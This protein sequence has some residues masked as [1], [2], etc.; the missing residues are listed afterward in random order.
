V[1]VEQVHTNLVTTLERETLINQS[2]GSS[3]QESRTWPVWRCRISRI[4]QTREQYQRLWSTR[5]RKLGACEWP[6][7][8]ALIAGTTSA[9]AEPGDDAYKAMWI[10]RYEHGT[11][12]E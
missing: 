3:R 4:L 2:S 11:Y 5:T 9:V 10:A 7:H 6:N 12:S 1:R 8:P